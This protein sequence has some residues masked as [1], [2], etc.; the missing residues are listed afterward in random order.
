MTPLTV[1]LIAFAFICAGAALGAVLRS[2]LPD[3]DLRPDVKDVIRLSMGLIATIAALVLGLL[4]ASAKGSF[5]AKSTKV[6]EITASIILIDNFL[7]EYGP[8]ALEARR[9]LR[10]SIEPTILRIWQEGNFTSS[11]SFKASDESRTFYGTVHNLVPANDVQRVAQARVIGL[12]T[13][14]AQARLSL[15]TQA[16]NGIPTPFLVVLVFWLAMILGS[17]SLFVRAEPIVIVALTVCSIST[18]GAIFLILEMDRPFSGIMAISDSPLRHAL[19][20]LL[21]N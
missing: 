11:A 17:F 7:E 18:A 12:S 14:L 20:P 6:K 10:A 4:V 2:A 15:F 16:G 8:D 1:S 3:A 13:D 9:H 5:D 19:P 21:T